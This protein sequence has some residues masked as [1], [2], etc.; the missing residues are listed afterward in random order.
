MSQACT[1]HVALFNWVEYTRYNRIWH[2]D[3]LNIY[4][5]FPNLQDKFLCFRNNK[6]KVAILDFYENEY[7]QVKNKYVLT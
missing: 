4:S 1:L 7:V 5:R 2:H 6:R 3:I